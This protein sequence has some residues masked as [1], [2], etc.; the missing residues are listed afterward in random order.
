MKPDKN[1]LPKVVTREQWLKERKELL[2]KEKDL[3]AHRDK[4]N[5]ERRRLPMVKIDKGYEFEGSQGKVSLADMFESRQQL[6]I[7]HFML[8]PDWEEGCLSCSLVAD[9]MGHLSH[10]HARDTNLVLVSRAP[11]VKIEAYKK[12]MGWEIPWYS[13]FDS[14]FNYDFRVT[15]D[16]EQ[17]SVEYNY[18]AVGE[19]GE[20]WDGWKGEMPGI[21]TFIR[22]D[23]SVFHTY[24]SYARG[25]DLLV[26][27]FNY[28]DL[29]ALGRQE[30]WEKPFG[31]SD[32]KAMQWVRRHDKYQYIIFPSSLNTS[33]NTN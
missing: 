10:L 11:F 4:L 12:R 8:D 25:L 15:I 3:T 7:Y 26:N 14:D 9:N 22:Y 13:S 1:H 5:A 16:P 23:D 17:G 18:Q 27:T 19:L 32:A 24:S 20:T 2:K 30:N 33:E 31:R 6:L 29:T 28:L 21:S